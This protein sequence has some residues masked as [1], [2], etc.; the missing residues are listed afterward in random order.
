MF[1][2]KLVS[3][4]V[5]KKEIIQKKED[6]KPADILPSDN[7]VNNLKAMSSISTTTSPPIREFFD[8][9]KAIG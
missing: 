3:N 2:K 8:L 4:I 1:E 6:A 9:V 5:E 7:K